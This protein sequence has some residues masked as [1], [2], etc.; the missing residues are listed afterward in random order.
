MAPPLKAK[1]F[2]GGVYCLRVHQIVRESRHREK[3]NDGGHTRRWDRQIDE[4]VFEGDGFVMNRLIDEENW[5]ELLH[6]TP[7]GHGKE[8]KVSEQC[9]LDNTCCYPCTYIPYT[10]SDE[11]KTRYHTKTCSLLS[12][13]HNVI[14]RG[15]CSVIGE[16]FRREISSAWRTGAD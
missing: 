5:V 15:D 8:R 13:V 9:V 12:I 16:R 7:G 14:S 1:L 2:L 6:W 11:L 3:H 4:V 10:R